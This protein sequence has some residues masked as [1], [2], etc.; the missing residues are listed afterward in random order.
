MKLAAAVLAAAALALPAAQAADRKSGAP[1]VLGLDVAKNGVYRLAWFDPWTLETLRGRKAPLGRSTGSW[2]FSPDRSVLAVAAAQTGYQD[3]GLLKLRFVNARGMRVLGEVALGR[4]PF[5]SVAWLRADR[6]LAVVRADSSIAVVDPSR[7]S[8]VRWV[9]LVRPPVNV[10]RL[11][12]G[13]ALLLGSEGSFAPAV[14]A[15][16]DAEG[17]LRTV[18]LDRISIGNV[19]NEQGKIEVRTPGFAL[20]AAGDRAFVV[21][22]DFTVAEIDLDT[23]RVAYHGGSARSPAKYAYGPARY[24]VWLGNGVL[25]AAGVDYSGDETKGEPV[26]LRLIETRDW[27]TQLVDPSV[28]YVWRAAGNPIFFATAAG[29][30]THFD[31]YGM[32]GTLRYQ[33]DLGDGEWL[34]VGGPYGYVCSSKDRALRVLDVGNGAQAGLRGARPACPTLLYGQSG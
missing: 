1:P 23:L 32:D 22:T 14:V 28:G 3:R 5:D 8:L 26:G 9:P 29:P 2:S 11:P 25:A 7:R 31:A 21:G 33:L 30:S 6:L 17:V 13:L 16:V 18:T 20:D 10:V 24:A 12:D 34:R 4:W 15:V 19:F 27:S